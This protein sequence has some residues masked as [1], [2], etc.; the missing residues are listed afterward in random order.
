MYICV[1]MYVY[2]CTYITAD[3]DACLCTRV[4]VCV[5]MFLA[6]TGVC[7]HKYIYMYMNICIY[8][9]VFTYAYICIY[10]HIHI[11]FQI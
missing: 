2:I 11:S 6:H 5:Y 1:Y 3:I 9:H 7:I 4:L 8:I 10:T